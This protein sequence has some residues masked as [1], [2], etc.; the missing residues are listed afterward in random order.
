MEEDK[1]IYEEEAFNEEVIPKPLGDVDQTFGKSDEEKATHAAAKNVATAPML[2][3]VA[4]LGM[5][6]QIG[7]IPFMVVKVDGMYVTLKRMDIVG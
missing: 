2:E 5:G 3:T 4:P 7:D 1:D 6:V